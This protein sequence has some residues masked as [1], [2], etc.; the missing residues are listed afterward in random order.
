M[1]MMATALAVAFVVYSCKSKLSVAEKLDLSVTPMQVVDDMEILQTKNGNGQMRVLADVMEKYQNDT[2]TFELF[3]KG[4]NV[5]AY[6][7]D[8]VL[9][10]TIQSDN[11]LHEKSRRG[12][13]QEL[14]MAFGNVVIKNIVKQ[15]TMETDT[16][17]WDQHNKE[18]YTDCY[19]RMYSP[20]GLMQGYGMRSDD[21][22]S[23]ATLMRPFNNFAVV[24]KDS[25]QVRIDSINF[26]G[27]LLKK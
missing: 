6:T 23:N 10:S 7:E 19:V 21:R 17:Y 24:V 26:I 13:G 15:E 3:P 4:L 25:T 16:I 12:N 22:A 20:D 27:P 8:G 5:Y 11:A 1:K 9:E 18:I 14:W 2:I